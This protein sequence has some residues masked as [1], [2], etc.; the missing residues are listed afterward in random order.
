MFAT[1]RP[2]S[3]F[4]GFKEAGLDLNSIGVDRMETLQHITLNFTSL[5]TPKPR[6]EAPATLSPP[7]AGPNPLQ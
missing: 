7:T 6:H 5:Q 1:V 3:G 2:A 4:H